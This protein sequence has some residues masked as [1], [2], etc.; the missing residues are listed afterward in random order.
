MD[1]S[2]ALGPYD[3]DQEII[4]NSDHTLLLTVNGGSNSISVFKIMADGQLAAVKGSPF[5]SHGVQPVSVGL[6]GN[7]LTVV[8]KHE[9]PAQIAD[10]SL[11]NYTRSGSKRAV[12]CTGLKIQ[13]WRRRKAHLRARHWLHPAHLLFLAQ[14]SWAVLLSRSEFR[15]T[16]CSCSHQ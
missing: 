1:A 7:I 14:I 12:S 16:R 8:N 9:D 11:P 3:S 10:K 15:R 4:V 5:S 2:L 13:R 6:N